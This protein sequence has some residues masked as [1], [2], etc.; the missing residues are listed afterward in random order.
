MKKNKLVFVLCIVLVAAISLGV[1]VSCTTNPANPDGIKNYLVLDENVQ[2]QSMT[3]FGASAAWWA[4]TVPQGSQSAANLA[5][6]LYTD[7]GIGLTIYRYNIG[8]GSWDYNAYE[9]HAAGDFVVYPEMRNTQSAFIAE[10]YDKSRSAADNFADDA[11]YDFSKDANALGFMRLCAEQ[12][13]STVERIIL[14]ANSPHYLL[15]ASGKTNGDYAYQSN[16]PKENYQA[17]CEYLMKYL[18]YIVNDM[19]L[20]VDSV[21]A[22]NEPQHSWGGEDSPQEG[23]HYEPEELAAF[24]DVFYGYL[25]DFNEKNDTDVKMDVFESGNYDVYKSKGRV[26][27]YIYEMSKYDYFD[28]I[29]TIS[30]HSYGSP[31]SVEARESFIYMLRNLYGD[32]INIEMSEICDMTAGLDEGMDS[33]L[34]LSEVMNKDF[35]NLG[36]RAWCW[37]MATSCDDYNDGIVTWMW[38]TEDGKVTPTKRYW[39]MGNYSKFLDTGDVRIEGSIDRASNGVFA[40]VFKK[41]DGRIVVVLTN[42]GDSEKK[43]N[44]PAGYASLQA[45]ETSADKDLENVYDGACGRAYTAAAGSV[46]TLILS[47]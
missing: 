23:C 36:A 7:E 19:G 28:E 31:T 45:W 33:A 18:D 8:G 27:E 41:A 37:W 15:T 46:T 20:T 38:G 35:V 22:I 9:D 44:L 12:E 5:T 29:D 13:G 6:S 25:K 10:N 40:T 4:Q 17:Y 16:L 21:S 26:M 14:F 2:Y 30:V 1:L 24:Y 32:K 39:V 47:K 3:G 34:W 11:N 43:I 42:A